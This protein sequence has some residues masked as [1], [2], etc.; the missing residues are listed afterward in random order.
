MRVISGAAKFDWD[1]CKLDESLLKQQYTML[2]GGDCPA[3]YLQRWRD[4]LPEELRIAQKTIA[5][6]TSRCTTNPSPRERKEPV[7]RSP[8]KRPKRDCETASVASSDE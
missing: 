8:S 7:R 2:N 1:A 6:K 4:M 5:E 3:S